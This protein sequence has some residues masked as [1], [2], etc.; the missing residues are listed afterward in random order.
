MYE[1]EISSKKDFK[2]VRGLNIFSEIS[3]LGIKGVEK[4]TYSQVYKIAGDINSLEAKTIAAELL[5]DKITEKTSVKTAEPSEC[6]SLP[7]SFAGLQNQSLSLI[8][9]F[10]KKGVTDTVAESVI[11]AVKDLGINK[12]IKA[13]AGHRYYVY[14]K[15]SQSALKNIAEKLLANTLIQEYKI[16]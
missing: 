12:D 1:I 16:F 14:G 15:I 13:S 10:Y 3:E 9:V 8:E 2:D 11:K 6:C 5:S 4:V 7:N